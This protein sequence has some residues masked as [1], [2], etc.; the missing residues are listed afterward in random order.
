M[1][2]GDGECSRNAI[3][4]HNP[5]TQ[6]ARREIRASIS[7]QPEA[8]VTFEDDAD[9][10]SPGNIAKLRQAQQ[11]AES[12]NRD[13]V[14]ADRAMSL[15]QKWL[16][17]AQS[18]RHRPDEEKGQEVLKSRSGDMEDDDIGAPPPVR[19]AGGNFADMGF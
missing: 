10:A 8:I 1:D 16:L 19:G 9:H 6:V 17:K 15:K 11:L 5:N 12:V 2:R 4:L 7:S 14:A 13:I 3:C 18:R